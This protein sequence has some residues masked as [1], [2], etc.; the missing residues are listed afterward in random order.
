[1]LKT[2]DLASRCLKRI[3]GPLMSQRFLPTMVRLLH[4]L[5]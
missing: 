2:G 1:L 3:L 4:G 5:C